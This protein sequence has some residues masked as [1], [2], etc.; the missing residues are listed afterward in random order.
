V[1]IAGAASEAGELSSQPLVGRGDELKHI[2]GLID[3]IRERGGALIVRGEAGI[4]KSALLAATSAY[5]RTRGVTVRTTTGAESEARLAF[6]GLHQLLLA[7]LKG[8]DRLPKP[9]RRALQ[10]ALGV[11]EDEAPDLFLVG[12]ATLGLVAET[13][14]EAPLLLVV[15]DAQWLD[16]SSSDVLAF[17]ARRLDMEPV[18]LLFAVREGTGSAVDDADVPE[19][20]L[21][22]L[23]ETDARALLELT[24]AMLPPDVKARFH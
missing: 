12:L 20:R 14:A 11:A 16:R 10:T 21:A 7:F 5:A 19:L 1:G 24:G 15:D 13:A 6:A 8:L 18:I 2:Y 9:Q 4:G 3:G 22:G 23:N 17:V